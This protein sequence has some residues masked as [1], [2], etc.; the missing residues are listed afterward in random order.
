MQ[1]WVAIAIPP[2]GVEGTDCVDACVCAGVDAGA[3]QSAGKA[4]EER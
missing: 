4:G 2:K 3:S 1:H